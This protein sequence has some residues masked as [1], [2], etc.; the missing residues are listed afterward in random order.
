MNE[1]ISDP[2]GDSVEFAVE[3]DPNY[4]AKVTVTDGIFEINP[5]DYGT[6]NIKVIASDDVGAS[7]ET[8]FSILVRE[9]SEIV[10]VY[11]NPVYNNL[12][13][14]PGT[15]GSYKVVISNTA[16]GVLFNDTIELSPFS[17]LQVSMSEQPVGTYYVSV[18]SQVDGTEYKGSVIKY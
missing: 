5:L 9:G 10:D 14:R 6:A 7:V 8:S 11:P 13:V 3:V 16:G 12:Y 18:I 4:I 17:P 15:E 2:D 1:Y